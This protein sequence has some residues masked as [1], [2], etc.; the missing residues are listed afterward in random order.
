MESLLWSLILF[1]NSTRL[2]DTQEAI[3]TL[4]PMLLWG[5]FWKRSAFKLVDWIKKI[6]L[7]QSRQA[8]V[9][10]YQASQKIAKREIQQKVEE[11]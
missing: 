5:C 7:H 6:H 8:N 2:K 11:E 10:Q 4:F 9:I 3:K 1:V